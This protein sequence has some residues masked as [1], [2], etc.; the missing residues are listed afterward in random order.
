MPVSESMRP[1][2]LFQSELKEV[3]EQ[4]A[5][6][7]GFILMLP[8]RWILAPVFEGFLKVKLNRVDQLII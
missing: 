8:T 4:N 1:V 6:V 2:F 3:F 5:A 7:A